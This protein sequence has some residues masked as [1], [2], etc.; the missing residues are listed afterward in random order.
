MR[1]ERVPEDVKEGLGRVVDFAAA[2][3][4]GKVAIGEEMRVESERKVGFDRK[5]EGEGGEMEDPPLVEDTLEGDQ[6]VQTGEEEL[7]GDRDDEAIPIIPD[8]NPEELRDTFIDRL[9][10][11]GFRLNLSVSEFSLTL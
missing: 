6:I 7:G 4:A 9:K 3:V 8:Q 5:D 1:E 11:V 2:S 10:N